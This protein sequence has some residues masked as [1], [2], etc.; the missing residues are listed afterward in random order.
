M[1]SI[2][3]K[4]YQCAYIDHEYLENLWLVDWDH[5]KHELRVTELKNNFRQYR[6]L[7]KMCFDLNKYDELCL[8]PN[9]ENHKKE[10]KIFIDE[11][12]KVKVKLIKDFYEGENLE[13]KVIYE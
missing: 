11:N 9:A 12:N 1:K 4:T 10:F 8:N 6:S 2:K 7:L 3:L 13:L 5:R